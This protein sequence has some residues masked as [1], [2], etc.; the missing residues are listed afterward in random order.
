MRTGVTRATLRAEVYLE[1]G[2][3]TLA[4]QT[5]QTDPRVN[6]VLNR[7]ERQLALKHSWP[8]RT[9]EVEKTANA[10]VQYVDLPTELGFTRV[11][12]VWCLFG[13]EWLPVLYGI[14]ARERSLYTSTMRATPIQRWEWYTKDPTPEVPSFEVWPIPG[15][16]QTLR[17]TGEEAAG[18]MTTDSDVCVLDGDA[19]VQAAAGELLAM[20]DQA[21]SAKLKLANADSII[22]SILTRQKNRK[23]PNQ[24]MASRPAV[25]PRPFVDFIPPSS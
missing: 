3:P 2:L 18:L 22:R 9:F 25:G 20:R 5:V 15:E 8:M 12:E 4:A 19:I 6:Q 11:N 24:N 21:E 1:A 16:A 14:G 23:L 10:D 17:F 13:T 7:V